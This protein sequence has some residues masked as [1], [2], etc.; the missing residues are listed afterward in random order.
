MFQFARSREV[1]FLRK[2]NGRMSQLF[3]FMH[4]R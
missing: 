3:Q 1:Q 4:T 2:E